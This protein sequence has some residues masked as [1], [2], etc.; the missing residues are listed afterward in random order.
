MTTKRFPP[1]I[2][3]F[4]RTSALNGAPSATVHIETIDK[5]DGMPNTLHCIRQISELDVAVHVRRAQ[6][7]HSE[8]NSKMD[9]TKHVTRTNTLHC[10]TPIPPSDR[11]KLWKFEQKYKAFV[12]ATDGTSASLVDDLYHDEVVHM[13]DGVAMDKSALT[14]FYAFML[15]QGT[16]RTVKKFQVIDGTH[17]EMVINSKNQQKMEYVYRALITLKDGKII[18]VEKIESVIPTQRDKRAKAA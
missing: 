10:N 9:D 11:F 6:S 7:F 5:M 1:S 8:Q 18:R 4:G 14:K 16:K 13:M 12:A 17:I 15:N 2:G 3:S